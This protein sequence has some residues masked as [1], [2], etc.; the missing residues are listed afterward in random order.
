M[1]AQLQDGALINLA[2]AGRTDCFTELMDRHLAA[3]K[4]RVGALVRNRAQADDVIQ[5]VLLNVWLHLSTFRSESSFR[6]WMTR[7]AINEALQSFRSER[8]RRIAHGAYDFDGLAAP[9]KSP[10]QLLADRE[11]AQTLREVVATLPANYQ[12][13]LILRDF[14]ELSE[15][16]TAY[17]LHLSLTAVKTRLRRARLMLRTSYPSAKAQTFGNCQETETGIQKPHQES[18]CK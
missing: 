4:K 7:I 16:E 11:R 18:A 10:Y 2:M 13:V 15:K 3:V 12:Q 1:T 6:A 9:C 8:R 17:S 5:E 14:Q